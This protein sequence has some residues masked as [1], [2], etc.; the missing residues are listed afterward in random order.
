MVVFLEPERERE[1][2]VEV[3]A[4]TNISEADARAT[5][6]ASSAPILR[7]RTWSSDMPFTNVGDSG[8]GLPVRKDFSESWLL[9]SMP[10]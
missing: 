9:V 6:S 2:A 4:T 10:G 1:R 5:A 3:L 8:L 7:A